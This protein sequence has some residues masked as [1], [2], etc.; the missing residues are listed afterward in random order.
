VQ[1]YRYEVRS[2]GEYPAAGAN[3]IQYRETDG[4]LRLV[5]DVALP[6]SK[7]VTF[8]DDAPVRL[9]LWAQAAAPANQAGL[10]I[11]VVFD[12]Q[13]IDERSVDGLPSSQFATNTLEL[14]IEE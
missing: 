10:T 13:V 14:T 3:G 12:G 7:T 9:Y 11:R 2:F 6:W 8:E 5:Q 4:E 1:S